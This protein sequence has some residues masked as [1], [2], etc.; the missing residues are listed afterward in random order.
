MKILVTGGAGFIG[1]HLCD[2][3]LDAGHSVTAFDDLS[4]GSPDN[5]R[6][7]RRHSKFRFARGTVLDPKR[8][9]RLVGAA[10]AVV[11]LAAA[12]GVMLVV[13]SPVRTIE[14]NIRGTEVVLEAAAVRRVPVLLAST[15]EVYGKGARVPFSEGDDSVLGPPDHGRWAYAASK[16]VD[17]F[18]ALAYWKERGL[19]VVIA[20][21]FNTV[22]PRQTG[23][24]G[25]VVPRF[26]GQAL[27]GGPITVYGDGRQTRC[28]A[29]V[30][31]V[32][33]ALERLLKARRA[34]GRAVNV[35]T[36]DEIS[37][38]ALARLVRR[39]INPKAAIRHVPYSRAYGEGFEDLR[40]RVPDLSRI[41]G[42]IGWRPRLGI[43]AIIDS[44]AESLR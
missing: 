33:G 19:Q 31:D 36:D 9:R 17:E 2:R 41:R 29:H 5:L 25:M 23:R 22:G 4:T 26:V 10:D 39:R 16:L 15:S 12:V 34:R 42:L 11:H 6:L 21:L 37:I 30:D 27:A 38:G 3:L 14:T 28:F 24:Y 43:E 44:V 8:T 13:K 7:A 40:R 20:R 32:T 18:L 35:G 1:S